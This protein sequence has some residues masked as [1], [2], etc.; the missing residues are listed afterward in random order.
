MNRNVFVVRAMVMGVLFGGLSGC[1]G[2]M[3]VD[4]I[5]TKGA[6]Q[7][8]PPIVFV[9]GNG[10]TA[11]I[12]QT[13]LWRFESNGWPRE[14]LHALDMPLPLARDD[15]T[16]PQEGRSST[17]DQAQFLAEEVAK[18]RTSTG[19]AKVVLIA[20]SRGGYAVRNYVQNM[21]GAASVSH[22][23]LSGVPN[24]GVW[25]GARLPNSEFNG[26]AAFLTQLNAPKGASNDEVTGPV[27]WMTL[28]SDSNDKFAQPDGVWIGQ[29]GVPTGVTF[30]GPALKGATN[31]VLPLR[32]H[33]ETAFHP[34][35]FRPMFEFVSGRA[36][37]I[38]SVIPEG[39]I[40]LNGKIAQ[41]GLAGK[42]DYQT[43]I[44]LVGAIVTV[45]A[46]DNQGLR[47][48]EHRHRKTVGADGLW[49]PFQ[50]SPS[51]AYEFVVSAEGYAHT[52]IYRAPFARSSN[53]VHMRPARILEA[54]KGSVSVITLNRSRG[55]FS[56]GRDQMS[57]DGKALPGIGPGVPGASV[58]KLKLTDM[59]MRA[60]VAEFNGE[61]ITV[62]AWP[63]A[64]NR[65]VIADLHQ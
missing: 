31:V 47:V 9:H 45:F 34:E 8:Y 58:A 61:R 23:V 7:Q 19:A 60:I 13:T 14:R 44:A 56:V 3:P 12:W 43:N 65:V 17:A 15:D 48:G 50:A 40:V 59:P 22:A 37:T 35:A 63:A 20:N 28:R 33:R 32:D 30:D 16:V 57:L 64:E 10:D 29:K 52:H 4:S 54:D 6:A 27:K 46:V 51:Q 26:S 49:G 5:S 39:E 2:V 24:H 18:I 25:V 1:V 62:R 11:G 36:L 21:G 55:Y 42:G 38:N 53:F 41:L